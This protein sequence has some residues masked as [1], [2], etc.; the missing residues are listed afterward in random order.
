MCLKL[1]QSEQYKYKTVCLYILSS[2]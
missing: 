1:Q 2:I